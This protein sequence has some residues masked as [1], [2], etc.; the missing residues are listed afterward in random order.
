MLEEGQN[1]STDGRCILRYQEIY[2]GITDPE[3]AVRST[4]P[5]RAGCE[6][7]AELVDGS[8][9]FKSDI[10]WRLDTEID[11]CR[12]A[13]DLVADCGS[14]T[15]GPPLSQSLLLSRR[16]GR[17]ET[18]SFVRVFASVAYGQLFPLHR[19]RFNVSLPAGAK[20]SR[21]DKS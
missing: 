1:I 6:T 5:V 20:R 2:L 18:G 12:V 7:R 8:L 3:G 15:N 14:L 13:S 10:P 4:R 9:R 11:R 16:A 21:Y 19:V 17:S